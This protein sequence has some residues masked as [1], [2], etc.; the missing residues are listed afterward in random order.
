MLKLILL[1]CREKQPNTFSHGQETHSPIWLPNPKSLGFL[2]KSFLWVCVVRDGNDRDWLQLIRWRKRFCKPFRK[3]SN[4]PSQLL[5][6]PEFL[7]NYYVF[8]FSDTR[9]LRYFSTFHVGILFWAMKFFKNSKRNSGGKSSPLFLISSGLTMM[10][11]NGLLI[12]K[13]L[14]VSTILPKNERKQFDWRYHSV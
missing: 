9:S 14:F 1:E 4:S 11:T 10:I 12:S 6:A 3:H 7:K 13:C 2:K 8:S 5:F